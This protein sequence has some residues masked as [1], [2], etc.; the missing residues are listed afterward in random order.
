MRPS[1]IKAKLARGEPVLVTTLHLCDPSVFELAGLLGF[2]GIWMDMEHHTYSVQTGS[3]L[4]RA[5]RVGSGDI[6]ARPAK[7]EFMRMQRMLEAGA[8]G[9]MYPRCDDAREA[10]EV[11]SW[12]KFAPEG[13]RGC[14]AAN[15]DAPYL[16]MPVDEYVAE[17]NRQTFL[18]VQ[19]ESPETLERADEIAAVDGVDIIMLGPGDFSI[20]SGIPGQF[21]HPKI[22]QAKERIA[23][24]AARAGKHWGCPA[25][26]VD[27]AR[28]LMDM[29]ARVVFYGGDIVILKAGLEQI[30]RELGPLGFTFDNR[31]N[32]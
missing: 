27:Q 28:E 8:H 23:E 32:P 29:G 25:G 15:P 20:L 31:L 24:A 13:R 21:G 10:A 9:I 3:E 1:R 2:D 16:A 30:Q 14:D 22:R 11:V 5:A 19:I 6:I 26:T 4:M 17:A 7:G 18:I 12:M